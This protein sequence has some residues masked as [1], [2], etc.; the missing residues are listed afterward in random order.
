MAIPNDHIQ[1]DVSSFIHN[2]GVN[3]V[4]AP[5][6]HYPGGICTQSPSSFQ[7]LVFV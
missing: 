6:Q 7:M 4:V 3:L 5:Q 1:M 2:T